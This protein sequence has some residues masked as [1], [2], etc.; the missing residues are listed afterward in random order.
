[1]STEKL[2]FRSEFGDRIK[3]MRKHLGLSQEALAER[4]GVARDTIARYERG[5]LSPSTEVLVAISSVDHDNFDAEWLLFG[6]RYR[7]EVDTAGMPCL[8]INHCGRL[9]GLKFGEAAYGVVSLERVDVLRIVEKLKDA[10]TENNENN[11]NN[12]I[13]DH[14]DKV[15]SL[16]WSIDLKLNLEMIIETYISKYGVNFEEMSHPYVS[17]KIS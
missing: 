3:R 14:L 12:E 7:N 4:V 5:E 2:Q 6:E 8:K 13:I 16:Y 17:K 11:K 9:E 1:M 15:I 10:L